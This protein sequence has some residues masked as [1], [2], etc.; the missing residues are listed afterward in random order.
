[1]PL[2]DTNVLITSGTI[3]TIVSTLGLVLIAILNNRK[4]RK[5]SAEASMEATLRERIVFRDEKIEDLKEDKA[6]L[7]EDKRELLD[8][9]SDLLER[10]RELETN[11]RRRDS[12]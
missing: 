11:E 4:E 7:L 12:A 1:M 6:K 5:G 8:E 3:A 2:P 9:K 10:I